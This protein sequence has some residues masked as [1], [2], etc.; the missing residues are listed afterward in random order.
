MVQ[1]KENLFEKV[2]ACQKACEH[3]F[4]RCLQ[5][6]D[7]K[8]MAECI[9][10]DRDCAD[11]CGMVVSF[12]HRQSPLLDESIALCIK[13]CDTCASEC[14]QHDHD[15]CKECAKACR[16]CEAACKEYLAV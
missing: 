6:E 8:M 13:A 16:E 1:A 3:C 9:R 7:V 15:H 12:S 5:E 2:M 11:I 10:T 14:E 4:D